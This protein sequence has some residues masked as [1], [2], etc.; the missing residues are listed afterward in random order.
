MRKLKYILPRNV[1]SSIYLLY[2]RPILEY[3]SELWDNCTVEISEKL[4][5]VQLEA[6]RI[7]TGLPKFASRA[8]IYYETG[9]LPLH[10]RRTHKK[11]VYLL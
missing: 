10:L 11:T 1:L 6:G 7:V 9:W 3:A 2:V 8:S 5:T 4:E